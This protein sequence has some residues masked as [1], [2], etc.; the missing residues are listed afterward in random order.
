MNRTRQK[1]E[2][3]LSMSTIVMLIAFLVLVVIIVVFGLMFSS[4]GQAG[5]ENLTNIAESFKPGGIP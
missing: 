4:H 5:V 1:A 3:E 2:I